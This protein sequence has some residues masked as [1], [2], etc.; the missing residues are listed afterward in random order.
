M[1]MQL[2]LLLDALKS[3]APHRITVVLPC[4]EYARQDKKFEAGEAI[5]PK[6]LLHLMVTLEQ[7]DLS[8]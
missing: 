8:P 5:A 2:L 7:I 6:L 3:E 1:L 4:V